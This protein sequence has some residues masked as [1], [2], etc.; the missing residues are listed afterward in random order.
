VSVLNSTQ[1]TPVPVFVDTDT[2]CDDALAIAW[3]LREPRARVVGFSTV[4]GNSSVQDTTRNLL[5][6]LSALGEHLPVTL[7]ATA[8]LTYPRTSSGALV[9]GPDGLWGAQAAHDLSELRQDAPGA[10]AAAAR[11]HPGLTIIALGPLT[12]IAR[13]VQAY[14]ADLVDARLVILGGAYAGGNATPVAEF[15]I[16]A[17]PHALDVVLGSPL[18]VE[19]VTLDAFAQIQLDPATLGP[20]LAQEGGPA[21]QLLAQALMGYGA[22]Q[23]QGAGGPIAIPDVAAVVYALYPELGT[24]APAAVR[25]VLDGEYTRGQTIIATTFAHR[26]S[27]GLGAS[28][29]ARLGESARDAGFDLAAIIGMALERAAINAQAIMTLDAAAVIDR[30]ESGLLGLARERSVGA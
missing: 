15:N 28:G 9:H 1:S 29:V 3:L 27:L 18:H 22:A 11:A 30:F 8:P 25:V 10:I 21:G 26:V 23:T 6:L 20:Q 16:F 7:G 14:P 19:L 5:T 13:A 12:N 24:P 2:G 4:F 17:D